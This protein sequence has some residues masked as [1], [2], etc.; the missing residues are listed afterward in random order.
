M[1][2][3]GPFPGGK[4]RPERDADHS[5]PFSA[6]IENEW[7]LTSCPHKRLH[8]V[9]WDNITIDFKQRGLEVNGTS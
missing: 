5:P 4:A 6:E 1:G 2:T 3:G 7:E 9:Q 8:G